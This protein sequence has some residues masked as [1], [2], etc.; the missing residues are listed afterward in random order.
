MGGCF[1]RF[2]LK[3]W[4]VVMLIMKLSAAAIIL[5]SP[6]ISFSDNFTPIPRIRSFKASRVS[7]VARLHSIYA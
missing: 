3:E 2:R 1:F 4:L 5:F 7:I 6:T